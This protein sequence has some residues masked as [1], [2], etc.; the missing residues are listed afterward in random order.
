MA[1]QFN[2]KRNNTGNNNNY[3]VQQ[4]Q[5]NGVNFL[6]TIR[7]DILQRDSIRIFRDLARGN[8]NIDQYGDYFLNPKLI[9]AAITASY[10]KFVLYSTSK[11][12]IELLINSPFGKD[13]SNAPEILNYYMRASEAYGLIYNAMM[14][15]RQTNDINHLY[16]LVNKISSYSYDI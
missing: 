9:N 12:G 11:A 1:K 10:S 8:I 15:I 14:S 2:N 3:F 7:D 4:I 5:R 13:Y 16:S 6:D